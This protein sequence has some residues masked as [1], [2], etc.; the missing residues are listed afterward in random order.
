VVVVG[1]GL[2]GGSLAR[3]LRRSGHE[4]VGVDRPAVLRQARAARALDAGYAT[5]AGAMSGADLLVFATPPRAT[6]RLMAQ[7]ARLAPP[8]LVVTDCASIKRVVMAEARRL[9]LRRFVGGHPI[10]GTEGRG[11]A[12]SKEDLFRGRSWV[13]TP[14]GAD[15]AAVRAVR[16]LTRAV[17][18]RPVAMTATD[19]DRVLAF[20]SHLPQVVAW[21]LHGAASSDGA[22]R[23]RLTLAGPGFRDMTRLHRSPRPLWAEILAGNRDELARALAAFTR[24][25]R[26]SL[27]P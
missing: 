17:G 9:G 21:A 23:R 19:H 10:A 1:L 4:V 15:S 5:L 26:A 27:R 13:L 25:L 11:F 16:R 24:A 7:A 6:L 20:L 22:A 12:A 2:V 8:S 18:A 14:E 3:A